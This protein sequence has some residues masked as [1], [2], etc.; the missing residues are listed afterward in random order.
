MDK[1]IWKTFPCKECII[2]KV[3]NKKCFLWP[4][5]YRIQDHIK[6]NH[7]ENICLRCGDRIE[8]MGGWWCIECIAPKVRD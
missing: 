1:D 4:N 2:K 5:I 7:L 3:C 8:I 6:E